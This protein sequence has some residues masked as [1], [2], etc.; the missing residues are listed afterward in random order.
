MQHYSCD[1]CGKLLDEQRFVVKVQIYPAFDPAE[2]SSA[3]LDVDHLHEIAE[4]IAQADPLD[5]PL[6]ED[7]ARREHRYDLCST[8]RRR[9]VQDPLGKQSRQPIHFSEN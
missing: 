5:P 4:L 1:M 7:V 3:D 2:L 6:A 9:Y 8:C